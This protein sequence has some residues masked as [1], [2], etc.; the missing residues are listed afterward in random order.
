MTLV[1]A[2]W[3][4]PEAL[5]KF[6]T[7][8]STGVKERR[9]AASKA[10]Q[11]IPVEWL[12]RIL[13]AKQELSREGGAYNF[14]IAANPMSAYVPPSTRLKSP[15]DAVKGEINRTILG[16][17][18]VVPEQWIPFPPSDEDL[19]RVW[20]AQVSAVMDVIYS[21]L[22]DH[23]DPDRLDSVA[24]ALP[25]NDYQTAIQIVWITSHAARRR[26]YARPEVFGMWMNITRGNVNVNRAAVGLV[27]VVRYLDLRREDNWAM[28]QVLGLEALRTNDT[29]ITYPAIDSL[30]NFHPVPYAFVLAAARYLASSKD[31]AFNRAYEADI[32]LRAVGES[33]LGAPTSYDPTKPS[34]QEKLAARFSEWLRNNE[35][36]LKERAKSEEPR[37]DAARRK[38]ASASACRR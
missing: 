3:S 29:S 8:P 30:Q 15:R 2:A 26:G 38:M 22:L 5:W 21:G 20:P 32:L 9:V 31:S 37:I 25:C 14:G 19:K 24:L 13:A 4:S 23:A 27:G 35:A 28:A 12:P 36:N 16:Y 6:L 1:R 10:E 33:P 18:F 11:I 7:S 17:P 34:E